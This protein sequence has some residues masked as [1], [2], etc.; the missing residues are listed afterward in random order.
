MENNEKKRKACSD[1]SARKVKVSA[2]QNILYQTQLLNTSSDSDWESEEDRN[3]T[4]SGSIVPDKRNIRHFFEKK[5]QNSSEVADLTS[6]QEEQRGLK[7]TSAKAVNRRGVRKAKIKG[8]KAK[9]RTSKSKLQA[10]L[11]TH[12]NKLVTSRQKDKQCVHRDFNNKGEKSDSATDSDY[13]TPTANRSFDLNST[14][15]SDDSETQFLYQLAAILPAHPGNMAD[16]NTEDQ[17]NINGDNQLENKTTW[18]E[19][20]VEENTDENPTTMSITAVIEALNK[21]KKEMKA[22]LR[23]E[24]RKAREEDTKKFDCEMEQIRKQLGSEV[25][26]QIESSK[27]LKKMQHEIDYW[28]FKSDTLTDICERLHVEI[29]DLTTRIENLELNN[30]KKMMLLTGSGIMIDEK[31]DAIKEIETLFKDALKLEVMV[32]D[33]F[34]L[35]AYQ[36]LTAPI[37]IVTQ[38]LEDKR[39]VM[40]VKSEF[41]NFRGKTGGKIFVNEYQ[42]PTTQERKRREK[43]V[44]KLATPANPQE[45][46]E[47][48]YNKLGLSLQGNIYKKLITPPS[49]KELMDIKIEDLQ[50]IMKLPTQKGKHISQDN[51]TFVGYTAHVSDVD[52]VRELYIKMKLCHPEVRHIVCAY[53]VPDQHI[54]MGNDYQDDGEPGAGRILLD[55]LNSNSLENRVIFV[56]RKYGGVKMGADRFLCYERAGQTAVEKHTGQQGWTTKAD[57]Q[58]ARRQKREVPTSNKELINNQQTTATGSNTQI[59]PRYSPTPPNRGNN[60]N[61]RGARPY[62][63]STRG[64]M[65]QYQRPHRGHTYNYR[66]GYVRKNP[67]YTRPQHH[68]YAELSPPRSAS[69]EKMEFKF[70]DPGMAE[71]WSAHNTGQ[72]Q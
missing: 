48:H 68:Q 19:A 35:G 16:D 52:Q 63:P 56:T 67:N 29:T 61:I 34:T 70:S 66:Q 59:K 13:L 60:T 9:V 57:R 23:D 71:E 46:F 18:Q 8:K 40:K 22:D 42:P 25:S 28:R 20:E 30:S 11:I 12:Q 72:W 37:V 4:P 27:T 54:Y 49:P 31:E 33:C 53:S 36:N 38:T 24:L 10:R 7:D 47:V 3:R 6:S 41:K 26:T 62:G 39:C 64:S 2:S 50:R 58:A 15:Q 14:H 1:T 17:S 51:S 55:F 5:S 32:D 21:L 45:E 69:P 65:Q 44:I 43:D